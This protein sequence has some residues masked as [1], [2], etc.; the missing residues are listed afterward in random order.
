MNTVVQNAMTDDKTI[1]LHERYFAKRNGLDWVFAALVLAGGLYALGLYGSSMDGYEK[2]ILLGAM[3]SLIAL[4]WFWRPLRVLM[5]V[6]AG[7]SMLAVWS[8]QGNLERAE[9]VAVVTVK[10]SAGGLGETC[11]VTVAGVTDKAP[12]LSRAM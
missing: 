10:A 9:T 5:L 12:K 2:G 3:P 1:V 8:Y 11:T 4:G 7:L 6:V